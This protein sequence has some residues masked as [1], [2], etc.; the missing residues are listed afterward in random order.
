MIVNRKSK[1][2]A[3]LVARRAAT[4]RPKQQARRSAMPVIL[5]NVPAGYNWGW[6]SREDPRMH[7]QVVDDAHKGLG[8]RVWLEARGKRVFEPEGDIPAKVLKK[9]HPLAAYPRGQMDQPHDPATMA[10][11][12]G[13][14]YGDYADGISQYAEPIRASH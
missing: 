12:H 6:Y 14:G 2:S 5:R 3:V 7:L 8:Y 10:H 9:L 13:S 1:G 11:P 4:R